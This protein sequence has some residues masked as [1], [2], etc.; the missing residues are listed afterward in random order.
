MWQTRWSVMLL[1]D[2]VFNTDWNI[3]SQ[4]LSIEVSR[5]FRSTSSVVSWE[6]EGVSAGSVVQRFA[7][8]GAVPVKSLDTPQTFGW[9]CS[10]CDEEDRGGPGSEEPGRC[11][12]VRGCSAQTTDTWPPLSAASPP[13]SGRHFP[14]PGSHSPGNTKG[15]DVRAELLYLL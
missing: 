6:G 13:S 2:Q 15:G 11:T 12:E 3:S 7:G 9:C 10:C 1:C 14:S 5:L 4:S 8:G